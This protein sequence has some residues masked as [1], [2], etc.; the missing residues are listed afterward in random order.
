M[1]LLGREPVRRPVAAGRVI[2]AIGKLLRVQVSLVGD[3][4]R[5]LRFA[6][7]RA[8]RGRDATTSDPGP[9]KEV[10]VL[11][12]TISDD[13]FTMGIPVVEKGIRT[14][15]VYM[16]ILL[17]LR[18][19]GKRD[20]AQLNSFDFV[21][22]LLLSNV[23]Q[24]AIIG[25]D[26]SLSGGLLGAV[27][28]VGGNALLVRIVRHSELGVRLFEG[29]P[30]ILVRDGKLDDAAIR[31]LGLREEDVIQAVRHQGASTVGEVKLA[32]LEPGGSILVTLFEDDENATKGDIRRLEQKL[33]EL[34]HRP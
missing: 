11:L 30:S 17:V 32:M 33:D 23:V 8:G 19:A 27:I 29:S 2:S 34:L 3:S 4:S 7:R 13:L 26:N 22:L 28:L 10:A 21:V 20:L 15:A 1:R 9:P 14:V 31:R 18:I 16:G 25:P 24:N 5:G 6:A 12:A